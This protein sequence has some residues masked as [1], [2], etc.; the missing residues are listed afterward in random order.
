LGIDDRTIAILEVKKVITSKNLTL[1][2]KEKCSSVNVIVQR[3]FSRME[4]LTNKGLPSIFVINDKLMP[5]KDY[6]RKLREVVANAST[7]SN[8]KGTTT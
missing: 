2:L 4:P 7:V 3:F 8:I 1:Q 6:I 5:I